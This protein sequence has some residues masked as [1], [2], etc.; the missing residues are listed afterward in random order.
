MDLKP[1]PFCGGKA[2]IECKG[3]NRV[4]TLYM[5]LDCGCRLETGETF[6]HGARWNKRHEPKPE[7]CNP[8]PK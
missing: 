1:C 5:C 8:E 6:D 2:T 3:N 4:S 7:L